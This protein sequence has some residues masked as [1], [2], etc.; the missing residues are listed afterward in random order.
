MIR[1][2]SLTAEVTADHEV[3]IT[4]PEDVPTGPAD[5]VVVVAPRGVGNNPTLQD[6][7][8]S[9][10]L[11]MWRDRTD[12]QDSAEFAQELRNKAWSRSE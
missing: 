3:R 9:E 1:T 10:F 2:I 6:L 8:A 4:L 7:L 11:G 12:I 5:I